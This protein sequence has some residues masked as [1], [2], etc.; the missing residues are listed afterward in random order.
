M[1]RRQQELEVRVPFLLSYDPIV[2]LLSQK[3][4]R[5][6]SRF[7]ILTCPMDVYSVEVVV[8]L[9]PTKNCSPGCRLFLHFTDS[10][11]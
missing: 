7:L 8:F 1:E 9:S 11:S 4:F 3:T 2:H 6:T 10:L 5:M